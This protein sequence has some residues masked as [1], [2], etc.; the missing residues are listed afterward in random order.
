[1]R[2][3]WNIDGIDTPIHCVPVERHS[4]DHSLRLRKLGK[5]TMRH[6]SVRKQFKKACRDI[7]IERT[8]FQITENKFKRKLNTIQV[9]IFLEK[10]SGIA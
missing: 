5:Y 10:V 4:L 6:N 8:L 1:M 7:Q 2:Y 3:G 9:W